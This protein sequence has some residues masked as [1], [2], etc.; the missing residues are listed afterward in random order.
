MLPLK[1]SPRIFIYNAKDLYKDE[2]KIITEQLDIKNDIPKLD[3]I[4]EKFS[5]EENLFYDNQNS[6]NNK[7]RLSKL[8]E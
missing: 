5:S 8:I 6:A 7:E 4:Y 1:F 2:I 3:E